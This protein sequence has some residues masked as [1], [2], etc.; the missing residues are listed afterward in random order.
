[1]ASP[2]AG[3]AAPPSKYG[4]CKRKVARWSYLHTS[5]VTRTGSHGRY[6]SACRPWA[7]LARSINYSLTCC[8]CP[9][10]KQSNK[11]WAASSSDDEDDDKREHSEDDE[12]SSSGSSDSDSDSGS[13]ESSTDDS[14]SDDDGK[15]PSK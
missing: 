11:F 15:G 12:S 9:S 13:D 2:E 8:P 6:A 10:P 3:A 5:S 14:S 1:L 4:E 7:S